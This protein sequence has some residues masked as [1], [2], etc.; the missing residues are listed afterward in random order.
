MNRFTL[1]T[2]Q[3]TQGPQPV[4]EVDGAYYPL[5]T[6]LPMLQGVSVRRLF[7]DWEKSLALLEE[8][9]GGTDLEQAA[10]DSEEVSLLAPILYPDKMFAVGGNYSGHMKEMGLVPEKSA[11]QEP[12]WSDPEKQSRSRRVRNGSIGNA[13]QGQEEKEILQG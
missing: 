11:L 8:Q 3:S 12:R 4:I 2:R 7:D 13:N 6:L 1:G 10:I 9:A 5:G